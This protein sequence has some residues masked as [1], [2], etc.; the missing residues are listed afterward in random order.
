MPSGTQTL[1]FAGFFTYPKMSVY[2]YKYIHTCLYAKRLICI[3]ALLVTC[4][5]L[6]ACAHLELLVVLKHRR[7]TFV[8]FYFLPLLPPCTASQLGRLPRDLSAIDVSRIKRV[9]VSYVWGLLILFRQIIK[10]DIS[11]RLWPRWGMRRR[12]SASKR[13]GAK[14]ALMKAKKNII[15]VLWFC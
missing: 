13:R 9:F 7:P 12:T 8:G 11:P 14:R 6:I 1:L 5:A 2:M 4:R 15:E 3:V 10:C